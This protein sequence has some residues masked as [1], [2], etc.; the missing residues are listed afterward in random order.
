[1]ERRKYNISIYSA[2]CGVTK[3]VVVRV[4]T[5]IQMVSGCGAD[6]KIY[7]GIVAQLLSAQVA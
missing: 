5:E 7:S 6:S 4:K 3:C 1:M 2:L